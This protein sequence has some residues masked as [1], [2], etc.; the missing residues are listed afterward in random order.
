MDQLPYL[1]WKPWFSSS[2]RRALRPEPT[3]R[4]DRCGIQRYLISDFALGLQNFSAKDDL[5][6]SRSLLELLLYK[7]PH[8]NFGWRP[9]VACTSSVRG[10]SEQGERHFPHWLPVQP[11]RVLWADLQN[12]ASQPSSAYLAPGSQVVHRLRTPGRCNTELQAR[13]PSSRH[14]QTPAMSCSRN[15]RVDRAHGAST[16]GQI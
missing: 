12:G 15:T 14:Q 7:R 10:D 8:A 6:A 13:H 2:V 3:E 11:A 5:Y 9:H 4:S 16:L 1:S